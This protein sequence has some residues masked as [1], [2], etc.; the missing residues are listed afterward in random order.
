[1]PPS[2]SKDKIR[3]CGKQSQRVEVVQF[4]EIAVRR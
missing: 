4:G 3:Q 2:K 1:M